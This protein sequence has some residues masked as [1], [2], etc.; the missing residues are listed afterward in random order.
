MQKEVKSLLFFFPLYKSMK[1]STILTSI[2]LLFILYLVL[3]HYSS[4]FSDRMVRQ[5]QYGVPRLPTPLQIVASRERGQE[6]EHFS[7]T[8]QEELSTF[9]VTTPSG[10][11]T[12]GSY[13]PTQ[14]MTKPQT[15]VFQKCIDTCNQKMNKCISVGIP[16]SCEYNYE[17]CRQDCS[18]HSR[19]NA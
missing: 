8:M 14:P 1:I 10:E 16:A 13:T 2:V 7:Q 9:L 5:I 11:S 3:Q 19:I 6:D 15:E 4:D 17:I 12:I 18:W